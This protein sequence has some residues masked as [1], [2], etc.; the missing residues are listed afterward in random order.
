MN[1]SLTEEQQF[2]QSTANGFASGTL[3]E[4]PRG[5]DEDQTHGSFIDNL[6]RLA[7][8]GFMGMNVNENYGGSEIGTIGFSLAITEIARACASTAVTV[9]VTNMVAEVIQAIGTEQQKSKYLPSICSGELSAAGFCLSEAGAGSDPASMQTKAVLKDGKWVLNGTKMWI[10]SAPYAGVFVVWAVTD[11]TQPRGK[12]ISCFLVDADAPGLKIG[13]PENKLG[14]HASK[15]CPVIFEDCTISE[16]ALLGAIN[17]GYKI[18]VTELAGGRIGIAS[19]ALGVGLE[20]MDYARNY[21]CEREQFQ[22]PI[23]QF[24]GIQWTLADTYTELEAARLL[25]MQAA[26]IKEAGQ[27]FI[28]QASMAK[29]Y[30]TEAAN[31]ACYTALQLSGGIGYTEDCPLERYTRDVRITTIYEGTSEIQKIVIARELLRE[32]G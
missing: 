18:A 8:L 6:K 16:D 17:D 9:S 29:L 13:P 20:A 21:I 14:Q 1:L 11:A 15:T 26:A 10:T 24:Q 7:E 22:K 5:E 2:I 12:G 27:P 30:T 23:S 25:T 4:A 31:R 28:K 3:A 32:V 19:L